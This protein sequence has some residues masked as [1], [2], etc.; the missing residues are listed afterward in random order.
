MIQELRFEVY[1]LIVGVCLP[2]M[3][4]F[5]LLP[6]PHLSI[7]DL[8][9]HCHHHVP[10]RM[11]WKIKMSSSGLNIAV[12]I[13]AVLCESIPQASTSLPNILLPAPVNSAA[14]G[15]AD[16]LAVAVQLGIEVHPVVGCCS[17]EL[18]SSLNIWAGWTISLPTF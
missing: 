1:P 16:V 5:K 15:I 12:H 9:H 8:L 2:Y 6:C 3:H 14:D 4:R 18:F 17:L 7:M 13:V 10:L 11:A